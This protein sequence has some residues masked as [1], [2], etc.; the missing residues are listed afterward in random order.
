VAV[1]MRGRRAA[2]RL[3]GQAGPGMEPETVESTTME[4]VSRPNQMNLNLVVWVRSFF[5]LP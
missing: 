1:G 3:R 5:S 4:L 2:P